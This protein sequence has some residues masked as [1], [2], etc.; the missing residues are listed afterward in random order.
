MYLAPPYY[1]QYFVSR[2]LQVFQ[3]FLQYFLRGV[4]T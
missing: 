4:F 3:Y 2:L 1:F